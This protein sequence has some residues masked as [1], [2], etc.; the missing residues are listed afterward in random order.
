M[1]ATNALNFIRSANAP[2]IRAGVKTKNMPRNSMCVSRGIGTFHRSHRRVGLRVPSSHDVPQEQVIRIS[3]P[4]AAAAKGQGIAP[5]GP[6][7]GHQPH[8]ENALHHHAQHVLLADQTT[9]K[10]CQSGGRHEQH[11]HRASQNPRIMSRPGAGF[12]RW[13]HPRCR[14]WHAVRRGAIG[15]S[16]NSA[17]SIRCPAVETPSAAGSSPPQAD[18]PRRDSARTQIA[19]I[20]SQIMD[21]RGAFMGTFGKRQIRRRRWL[22]VKRKIPERR[23]WRYNVA[24]R[25]KL[26]KNGGS[27]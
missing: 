15:P 25:G 17:C 12:G 8:Q 27:R 22:R 5:K 14:R 24:C 21:T 13:L 4:A 7:D 26:V 6:D 19:R 11:Q 16:L 2:Q 23:V 18:P 9:V 20:G 1:N 3:Q 10:Q